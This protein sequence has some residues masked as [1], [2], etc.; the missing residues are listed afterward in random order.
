MPKYNYPQKMKNVVINKKC[1]PGN[2]AM[3]TSFFKSWKSKWKL[4]QN[5][6]FFNCYLEIK[7]QQLK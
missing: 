5:I 3:F 7:H 6:D 1:K 4:P 2:T